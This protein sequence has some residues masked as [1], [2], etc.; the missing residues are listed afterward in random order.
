[1]ATETDQQWCALK[2]R[3]LSSATGAYDANKPIIIFCAGDR[4]TH[5]FFALRDLGYPVAAFC[6]NAPHR[7][8]T[9]F[10]G[11]PV[12]SPAELAE[13][14]D[15]FVIVAIQTLEAQ[16]G[17][18]QQV[19]SLGLDGASIGAFFYPRI[20][21]R[22]DAIYDSLL[23]DPR[24]REVLHQVLL[25]RFEQ[26]ARHFLPVQ[27]G[28]Q[29]FCLP[30]LG[31]RADSEEIF[32]D[33]G[34]YDGDTLAEFVEDRQGRFGKVFSFEPTPDLFARL[35]A[36]ASGLQ[37]RWNLADGKMTLIQGGVGDRTES[38][39]LNLKDSDPDGAGN[40][41][42]DIAER[43]G[44][45]VLVH[46]LDDFLQGG[47]ATYIKADIE[48]FELKLIQGAARTIRQY[49][50]DLAICVYHKM[51]DLCEIPE[52]LHALNPSYRFYLRHHHSDY[53]ETVLYAQAT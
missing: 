36:R 49:A 38:L 44:E 15:A 53:S 32:V 18:L 14:R 12:L 39:D 7:H 17:I 4:G 52:C 42:Y 30:G 16:A 5:A 20:M 24:S 1:M 51:T 48:G 34:A 43:K 37:R 27:E 26:D 3:I 11:L 31:R 8:G 22:L 33:A 21:D 29:Y 40:S 9:L 19:R 41:F 35:T 45:P 25:A 28:R 2:S 23:A 6:D 13:R 46:A 47:P 50:P 10:H